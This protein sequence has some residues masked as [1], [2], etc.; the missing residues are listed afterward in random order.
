MPDRA[1]GAGP[2]GVALPA[3][4]SVES[5]PNGTAATATPISSVPARFRANIDPVFTDVD[6]YSFAA[7]TGD[8]IY[9]ATITSAA[10]G[11][12][13]TTLDLIAPD[14]TTV[15][16]SDDEHGSLGPSSSSIAGAT[17]PGNATFYLKVSATS[18]VLRYELYLEIR[19]GVP[20]A[21]TENNDNGQ[22]VANTGAWMS[23]DVSSVDI[24]DRFTLS[25]N[26]GDTVF[27]SADLDPERD[28]S[29]LL[30][31]IGIDLINGYTM[32]VDDSTS[33]SPRSEA[34][35]HSIDVAGTYKMQL[36]CTSTCPTGGNYHFSISV[37]PAQT[38]SCHTYASTGGAAALPDPGSVFSTINVPDD[39][40]TGRI[41]IV[42]DITHI[43]PT[44]VDVLL[45]TPEG[46]RIALFGDLGSPTRTE[47]ETTISTTGGLPLGALT[48]LA[49]GQQP[50]DALLEW[51]EDESAMGDWILT[52][53][54]DSGNGNGGILNS[55]GL[56]ICDPDN[57]VV[58]ETIYSADFEGSD[59]GFTHSGTDD[60]WERGTPSFAPITDCAGGTSCWKTDLD[61]TYNVNSDQTLVSP[62]ISLVGRTGPIYASW[63]HKFQMSQASDDG[64]EVTIREVG[65]PSNSRRLFEHTGEDM[66]TV[67]GS[68][69]DFFNSS[70]G[71]AK[72]VESIADFAGLNVELAFRLD[73][74]SGGVRAGVA[75][76]EVIVFTPFIDDDDD[77]VRNADDDCPSTPTGAAVDGAGCS[78]AEVQPDLAIK[79][80]ADLSTTTP[81]FYSSNPTL[82]SVTAKG[83]RGKTKV[84][85][86]VVVNDGNYPQTI[87][88]TGCA[89]SKGFRVTYSDGTT[90]TT[91]PPSTGVLVPGASFGFDLRV[92]V[93]RRGP[94][95]LTCVITAPSP[96]RAD[97]VDAVQPVVNVP[98]G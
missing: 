69:N 25:L 14:G 7:S 54:D 28:A 68:T 72:P 79:R 66:I 51:I 40:V 41:A 17:A 89:S 71:W 97:S 75:V 65:N 1:T 87:A 33:V 98:R 20:T 91:T 55:W 45:Q 9:A 23:G 83:K 24:I 93:L 35:V 19:S 73:S 10:T 3:D 53:Y 15:I 96:L 37:I 92:K 49:G 21:E 61:N 86:V 22:A 38:H 81:D 77:G 44:D 80:P 94:R 82:Q 67:V 18:A 34:F 8:R 5:E 62:S 42:V 57:P 48:T 39:I 64:Y 85:N 78:I 63:A 30:A 47:I 36:R 31:G 60:Q 50:E 58:D 2:S 88:V 26:V 13:N 90:T 56:V 95:L 52:V 27:L 29:D 46:N 32:T 43:S 59:G 16:Q 12:S 11:G 6:F 70:A 84:F 76:D 4:P 74:D